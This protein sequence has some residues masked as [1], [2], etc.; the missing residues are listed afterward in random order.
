[1]PSFK[2]CGR[3]DGACV[4]YFIT[5]GMPKVQIDQVADKSKAKEV[6][7]R[8]KADSS[9]PLQVGAPMPGMVAT[10]AVSVG[11]HVKAGDTLLTLEAMK[12]FTTVTSACDGTVAELAVKVGT[13]VDSKDLMLRLTK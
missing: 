5:H 11:S 13:I 10:I 6:V 8:S 7:T 9:D 3:F 1:L 2:G 12:M 4:Y